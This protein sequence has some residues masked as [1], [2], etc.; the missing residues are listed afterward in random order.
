MILECVI[1][2]LGIFLGVGIREM[3]LVY[4]YDVGYEEKLR[5]YEEQK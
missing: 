2:G 4:R 5:I 3:M 1:L